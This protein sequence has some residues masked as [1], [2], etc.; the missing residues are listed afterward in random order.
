MTSVFLN[1]FFVRL[2]TNQN[3]RNR[4]KFQHLSHV[5]S[6]GWKN[7]NHIRK[8]RVSILLI[9]RHFFLNYEVVFKYEF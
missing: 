4:I 8:I 5:T 3:A 2:K 1:L 9:P 7:N 6:I